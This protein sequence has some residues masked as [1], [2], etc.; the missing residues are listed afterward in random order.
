MNRNCNNLPPKR[1]PARVSSEVIDALGG[2]NAV[3]KLCGIRP[4]S[5]SL[6]RTDG[7]P[8]A[9]TLFLR[10]RFKTLPVM[11]EQEISTF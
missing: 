6:W 8:R 7:M 4:A 11:R 3:A 10:E 1:L 5:V 9:W 2:T